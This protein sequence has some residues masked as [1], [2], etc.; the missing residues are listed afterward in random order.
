VHVG[1]VRG[2]YYRENFAQ[3]GVDLVQ[4]IPE[5]VTNA[6]ATIA[7]SGRV[8]GRIDLRFG[9]PP[10]GLVER[11]RA[12]I[13]TLKV[14]ALLD[15]RFE[16]SCTDDGV[17]VNASTVERRMGAFSAVEPPWASSRASMA[18]STSL[19][20]RTSRAAAHVS[21]GCLAES[22][23]VEAVV[24][25]DDRHGGRLWPASHRREAAPLR[26]SHGPGDQS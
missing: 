20:S 8:R 21:T 24:Q 14:P 4:I 7:V 22:V 19:A 26:T 6:D 5:L 12:Q 13:R 17:G 1:A 23:E 11:W 25:L 18:S 16:V 10:A 15:W 3:G 2:R 9:A